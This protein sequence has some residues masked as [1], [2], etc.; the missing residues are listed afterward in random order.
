M[1][2]FPFFTILMTLAA[3]C[4]AAVPGS[5]EAR[6]VPLGAPGQA[7]QL[8]ADDSGNFFVIA[9]IQKPS[10]RRQILVTKTDPQGNV[11]ATF[12]FG[13]STGDEPTGAAVDAQG[14]LVVCGTTSSP[15]FPLVSPVISTTDSP[16]GFI[17][18]LDANLTK[19]LFSTRLGGTQG[20]RPFGIG[21]AVNAVALDATGNIYVTGTTT[22]NDFPIT[23]GAFQTTPPSPAMRSGRPRARL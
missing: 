3:A 12:E 20:A 6:Y 19:I 17:V 11:L 2:I 4:G 8:A 9:N 5:F 7:L 23:A 21:A 10:G 13:G 14:N 22:D 16:A 18:K 1:R 15:D